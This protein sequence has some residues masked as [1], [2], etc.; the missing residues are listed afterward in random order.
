MGSIDSIDTSAGLLS[1]MDSAPPF[2]TMKVMSLSGQLVT[3]V[4]LKNTVLMSNRLAT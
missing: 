2:P 3:S 4:K 1:S